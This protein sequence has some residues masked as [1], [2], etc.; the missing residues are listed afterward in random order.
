MAD[1]PYGVCQN[2]CETEV[3]QCSECEIWF[4]INCLG[5][6]KTSLK[7]WSLKSLNFFCR[8]CGFNGDEYDAEK[9]L[10]SYLI[11]LFIYLYNLS[12]D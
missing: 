12:F 9:A 2:Q 5:I 10:L 6:T 3:I 8:K 1:Y 7:S 11:C 4:H